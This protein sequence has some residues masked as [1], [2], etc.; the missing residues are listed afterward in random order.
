MDL[1]KHKTETASNNV[2]RNKITIPSVK[3]DAFPLA[4]TFVPISGTLPTQV[5]LGKD[6]KSLP[7]T[8]VYKKEDM[9]QKPA[10]YSGYSSKEFIQKTDE[11]ILGAQK[12]SSTENMFSGKEESTRNCEDMHRNDLFI[13]EFVLVMDHDEDKD[14]TMDKSNHSFSS[15]EGHYGSTVK[16]LSTT[17]TIP[18][19]SVN[20]IYV[21]E[22]CH[23]DG[24]QNKNSQDRDQQLYSS[25]SASPFQFRQRYTNVMHTHNYTLS[26]NK[27]PIRSKENENSSFCPSV[28]THE[29][30]S[31]ERFSLASNKHMS[32]QESQELN[33]ENL[34]SLRESPLT[35]SHDPTDNIKTGSSFGNISEIQSQCVRFLP[36]NSNEQLNILSPLPIR[37][38]K[39]P[40]CPSPSPLQSP[41]YGSS[42]TLSSAPMSPT[43]SH[44]IISRAPS[45]LSF[46]TSL[47]RSK[48]SSQKRPHAPDVNQYNLATHPSP[49]HLYLQNT[50]NPLAVTR[51]SI[52][53]F[54][55]NNS[56]EFKT[57]Q[58]RK[59]SDMLPS[60]SES[61]ISQPQSSF[62][63][64]PMRTLSPD[65]VYFKPPSCGLGPRKYISSP[66]TSRENLSPLNVK[67]PLNKYNYKPLKKYSIVGKARK[68]TL[69]PPVSPHKI[70]DSQSNFIS[71]TQ[72]VSPNT[73]KYNTPSGSCK[74]RDHYYLTDIDYRPAVSP[75]TSM[76]ITETNDFSHSEFKPFHKIPSENLNSKGDIDTP[77][78]SNLSSHF[79]LPKPETSSRKHEPICPSSDNAPSPTRSSLSRCSDFSSSQ[80]LSYCSDHEHQQTYKIKSSYKAFAAIPTNTLLRDQKAIDEPEI[81][82]ANSG[83]DRTSEERSQMCTPAQLRQQTEELCAAI[84]EVLH[85][86]L[87]L[88]HES[89]S[90]SSVRKPTS[91]TKMPKSP[92]KSA[93]RET[94]YASLQS[95]A[96]TNKS[97]SS[98]KPG[99]IR[100]ITLRVTLME[101]YDD[102][103]H[104]HPYNQGSVTSGRNTSGSV[105]NKR[106][107]I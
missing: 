40:L 88:Q 85:D 107:I 91:K 25:M 5:A 48:K 21:P 54:S 60:A 65:A 44:E 66:S 103:G 56:N 42:C 16:P 58:F 27:Y 26:N 59:Q 45:R 13:A 87:P 63:Q 6:L 24:S 37:I 89:T 92:C 1:G 77:V 104:S 15:A 47:L 7:K 100:P 68:V 50:G 34:N 105:S 23:D 69:S 74:A 80:S 102:I 46:L 57:V 38:F 31:L 18:L 36:R 11:N 83:V 61:N 35:Q 99:V 28:T 10:T 81:S 96:K 75:S 29:N 94:K 70:L 67:P 93:G 86:P 78:N 51:K 49:S 82:K 84:D 72:T 19:I 62:H 52:S 4:F 20:K 71:Q 53:C 76:Y 3:C 12:Q 79:N 97:S 30:H 8:V 33:I 14:E 90:R 39:H 64:R 17:A 98:T 32:S 2:I 41:Y 43:P 106:D 9:A 73:R 101:Q 22:R 95:I 55:L